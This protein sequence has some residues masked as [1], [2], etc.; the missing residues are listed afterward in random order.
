MLSWSDKS[1]NLHPVVFHSQKFMRLKLNYEIHNKELLVIVKAFKQWKTCLEESKDSI[2]VYMNHKNLIYFT[3]TK[4]LN[5]WQVHWSEELLNFNFEIHYWKGSENIKADALSWRSDY[6]KD[7]SQTRESVLAL[8][9]NERIMYN[10]K[11]LAVMMIITNDELEDIIWNEYLKDKQAQR[12]L[13]K[14]IKRFKKINK[15]LL[16]FQE[17]VYVS[18]HQQRDTIQIYHNESLEEYCEIHKMIEA[19]SQLYYFLH[20]WEKVRK[21][22]D[23]CDLCHKIKLSRHRPYGK[24]KQ[25]LT[26]D[27]FWASVVMNFIVKLSLSKKPLTEVFYNSILTIVD[28]LTKEVHFILYK[29]ASNAEELA[30]T[31]L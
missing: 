6:I 31:F 20:M 1:E 4:V 15:G 17:L 10:Y 9:K 13:E 21:Y 23:K 29:K 25:T 12:V 22:V 5:W 19:I 3:T 16:L 2:Q 24:M 27:Q 30:Y 28:W 26:S 8:Q 7:K 18:E 14:S 11:I